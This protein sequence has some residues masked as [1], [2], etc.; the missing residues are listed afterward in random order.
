MKKILSVIA[1]LL[2]AILIIFGYLGSFQNVDVTEEMTGPFYLVYSKYT[3][4]YSK[5]WPT[6]DDM[7]EDFLAHNWD[8]GA[9]IGIFY[10]DPKEVAS[11]NLRADIGMLVKRADF[12]KIWELSGSYLT[13]SLAQDKRVVASFPYKNQLSFMIWVFKVYPAV[14]S[15]L[16]DHNYNYNVPRIEIYNEKNILYLAEIEQ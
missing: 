14:S 11:E 8:I 16:D 2:I 1:F 15:F 13:K 3:G 6:M 10:D 9:G 4:D 7:Y 5:M 12:A